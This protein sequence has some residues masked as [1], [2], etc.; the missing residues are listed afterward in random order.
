ML[1]V[2]SEDSAENTLV[3]Q[4][5]VTSAFIVTPTHMHKDACARYTQTWARRAEKAA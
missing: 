4:Q 5:P 3:L 1:V 2:T